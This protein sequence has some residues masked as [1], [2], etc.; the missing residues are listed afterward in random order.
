M[1][2]NPIKMECILDSIIRI[3]GQSLFKTEFLQVLVEKQS[4]KCIKHINAII[5]QA[6]I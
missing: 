3:K 5:I 4:C 1:A 2:F 6:Y